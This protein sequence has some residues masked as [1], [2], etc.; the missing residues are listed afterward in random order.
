MFKQR[1]QKICFL[2]IPLFVADAGAALTI[3][4][5]LLYRG[6]E[7]SPFFSELATGLVDLEDF[8]DGSLDLSNVIANCGGPIAARPSVDED[9]GVI[10]GDG[11][12]VSFSVGGS[13]RCPNVF[14]FEFLPDS[15]GRL[16]TIIGFVVVD[17]VRF[18]NDDGEFV[19]QVS[20]NGVNEL[21]I[22]FSD[23][24]TFP[25]EFITRDASTHRFVGFRSDIG[26]RNLSIAAPRIDHLQVGIPEPQSAVL[27]IMSAALLLGRR[28]RVL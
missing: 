11:F 20:L 17:T 7:D 4:G 21:G 8:E 25:E 16:P 13:P 26:I 3:T 1:I 18:L 2:V 24:I 23:I 9:D 27:V 6:R 22:N 10:D 14:D 19:H 28:G 15:Q 5:P 12:G